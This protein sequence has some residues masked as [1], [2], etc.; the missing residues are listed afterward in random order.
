MKNIIHFYNEKKVLDVPELFVEK[1][2][3]Y[4]IVGPNGSGKTTL[5]SIMSLLFKPSKGQVFFEGRH[6]QYNDDFS[7]RLIKSMTMV[8]QNPYLFNMSVGKN[9]AYGLYP[10]KLTRKEREVRVRCALDMVGLSGFEKRAARELSGG[11]AQLVALARALALEPVVL[12]LDEPTANVDL[13][14][15]RRFEGI[16]SR[17][18]REQGTTIIMTSHNLSQA[19]R[20]AE[21]VISI[22]DGSLVP[23]AMHNLF[24]GS[25]H[26]KQKGLCF[27]TGETQIWISGEARSMNCTHIAIDPENI[28]VSK[29]PFVSSARN[30]FEGVITNITDQGGGI[31]LE[32]RSAEVFRALITAV[33]LKEMDLNVGSH[34]YLT[35]KASSVHLL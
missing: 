21:I 16:I 13:R 22:F 18:N 34:V 6:V 11:E 24:S 14:H 10:R 28:I 1:G 12:F 30:L 25:V 4:C 5:L 9:V 27:D 35:F 23:S 31:L 33:S 3:T 32:V 20:M 17:I 29:K 15:M 8:L 19:Y 2:K 7:L 26:M